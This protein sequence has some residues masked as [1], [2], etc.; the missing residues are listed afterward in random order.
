[1]VMTGSKVTEFLLPRFE[2]P[3]FEDHTMPVD[4]LGELSAYRRIVVELAKVL[5]R[6]RHPQRHRVRKGFEDSFQLKLKTIGDGSAQP[7]LLRAGPEDEQLTLDGDLFEEAQN[8]VLELIGDP[9]SASVRFPEELIPLFN[10]FGNT[11]REDER[12]WMHTPGNGAAPV[13]YDRAKRKQ[14]ILSKASSYEDEIDEV[15]RLV[16]VDSQ[17]R[18]FDFQ[19][20]DGR[21]INASVDPELLPTVRELFAYDSLPIRVVGAGIRNQRDELVRIDSV[22]DISFAEDEEQAELLHIPTRIDQL[23]EL[24]KGWLHSEG[25]PI[26]SNDLQFVAGLLQ[27]AVEEQSLPRPY[28]YPTPSG[29]IQAEWSFQ[30]SE[31]SAEFNFGEGTIHF[32]GVHLRTRT[33]AEEC[34]QLRDAELSEHLVDFVSRF[35]PPSHAAA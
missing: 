31:V 27:R 25:E 15:G 11:L 22:S 7:V 32:H 24:E 30:D 6:E 17:K 34:F 28:L 23:A 26:K 14:I 5:F 4:V 8:Q 16:M 18:S 19:T 20:A 33:D 3:R 12:I 21:R 10:K 13:S 9:S 1:M 35:A 2:G 29:G